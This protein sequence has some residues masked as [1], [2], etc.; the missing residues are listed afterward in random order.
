MKKTLAILLS[1]LLILALCACGGND[2]PS[3]TEG[4]KSLNE[5][6][7]TEE[8]TAPTPAPEAEDS[9]VGVYKLT[10]MTGEGSE[11]MDAMALMEAFGI[12][13]FLV[14]NEDGTGCIDSMGEQQPF[15]WSEAGLRMQ[16]DDGDEE[17][18]PFTYE[19]GVLTMRQDDGGLEFTKLNAEELADYEENGSG[20]PMFGG[21]DEEEPLEGEPST[22]P[23]SGT[24]DGHPVTILGAEAIEDDDGGD[25][26]RIFYEFTNGGEELESAYMALYFKAVQDGEDLSACYLYENSIPDDDDSGLHL[27]PGKTIR[28]TQIYNYDPEGGVIGFRI[29]DLFGGDK[30]DYF[31]D[32]KNPID[33][34]TE[35]FVIAP[36]DEVPA[37]LEDSEMEDDQVSI[38]EYEI[39]EDWDSNPLIRFYYDFTNRGDEATSCYMEYTFYAFQDGVEL[40]TGYADE[41]EDSDS[42]R[43]DDVE[44]GESLICSNCY[45]LRSASPVFFV[46]KND[47]SGELIYGVADDFDA[48][49]TGTYHL[50]SI[51]GITM[52]EYAEM[53]ETEL[54]E[55]QNLIVVEL[56]PDGAATWTNEG[57]VIDLNWTLDGTELT[58]YSPEE[59]ETI[60]GTLENGTMTFEMEDMEVVLTK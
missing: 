38:T 34:P 13:M 15:N 25:A 8:T 29:D 6:A 57:E 46:V 30:V 40:E 19:N 43:Y 52:T 59:D 44:P 39:T 41:S 18:V 16:D 14:L 54:E 31:I 4:P 48:P 56:D 21:D 33:A 5:P 7:K 28:C 10:N 60:V 1:L 3:A 37:L 12:K 23:V 24:V 53:T 42:A 50:Y 51:M 26:M 55:A 20:S 35:P 17:L 22:G 45:L 47:A 49:V 36:D 2:S 27:F 9:P 11:D 32:P 58:L